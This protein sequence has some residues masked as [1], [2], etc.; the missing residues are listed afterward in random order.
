MLGG[1][2]K[3]LGQ[4]DFI[5]SPIMLGSSI[6]TGVVDFVCEP[7]KGAME[8]SGPIAFARGVAKGSS[9]LVRNTTCGTLTAVG[10]LAGGFSKALALVSGDEVSRAYHLQAQTLADAVWSGTLALKHSVKGA[11]KGVVQKPLR[12]WQRNG[13]L[14]LVV[15]STQALLGI[16]LQPAAGVLEL[17]SRTVVGLGREVLALGQAEQSTGTFHRCEPYRIPS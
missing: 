6:I 11:A 7:V 3:I 8:G 15:G 16:V 2:H 12:G 4:V 5:G 17:T 13:S 9:S 10:Q 1:L 14:G